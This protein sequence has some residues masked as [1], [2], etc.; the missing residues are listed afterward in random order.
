MSARRPAPPSGMAPPT[1]A[2]LPD[3]SEVELRPLAQRITDAHLQRHLE[4]VERYGAELARDW[5]VH[6]N[7]Y[8]L[9]WAIG[10]I[11]LQGQV[12][13]LARVLDARGYPVANLA[14]NLMTGASIVA[15]EI[16]GDAGE[17]I[18]ERMRSAARSLGEPPA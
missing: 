1:V 18:A 8:L 14:D 9:E 6:D 11:D 10:D 12:A 7:Q 2:R 13:W 5:G 4:D 16:P 15:A 3:G 17:Q